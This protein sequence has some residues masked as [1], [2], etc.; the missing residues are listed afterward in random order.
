VKRVE[1]DKQGRFSTGLPAGYYVLVVEKSA[2]GYPVPK[3]SVVDVEAG[4]VSQV[5]LTLD[6]GI[7]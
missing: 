5:T 2:S 1:S 4:V 6:T 3:P 7:R